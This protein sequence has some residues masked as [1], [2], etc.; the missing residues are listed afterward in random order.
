MA[1]IAT[2]DVIVAATATCELVGES[3]DDGFHEI[4]GG[5][6]S[7]IRHTV[8]EDAATVGHTEADVERLAVDGDLV[9]RLDHDV[10]SPV[11]RFARGTRALLQVRVHVGEQ[12]LKVGGGFLCLRQAG[13]GG[14]ATGG[15]R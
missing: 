1:V 12:L 11:V 5:I 10:V 8:V 9:G 15:W 2:V 6:E 4:D 14:Y 7:D 13:V 3:V